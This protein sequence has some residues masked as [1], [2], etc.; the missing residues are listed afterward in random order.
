MFERVALPDAELS[1]LDTGDGEPILFVHGFPLDHSMWQAQYKHFARTHRCLVPDLRG[2]G[3]STGA[4]AVMS[5]QQLASDLAEMLD[6]LKIAEP[7]TFCGLSMGG[8]IAWQFAQM[9]PQRLQRL[10]LCDTRAASDSL[11]AKITRRTNAERVLN[12][13]PDFLTDGMLPKLFSARSREC[14]GPVMEQTREVMLRTNP[15]AI[16]G[17]LHG[18]ADRPDMTSYLAEIAVPVLLIVGSDD[19]LTPATEMRQMSYFLPQATFVEI[20]GAGH[21]SPLEA[22]DEVNMVIEH[23]LAAT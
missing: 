23:F 12:E 17:A 10:I 8:Y 21:M 16:A 14:C 4:L 22:P 11:E 20:P 15:Q 7:V 2:F 5:M 9:F 1:L 6:R 19:I 13:G 18:M 3:R